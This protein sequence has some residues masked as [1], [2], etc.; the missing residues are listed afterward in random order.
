MP[1]ADQHVMGHP[2]LERAVP[3]GQIWPDPTKTPELHYG[4]GGPTMS[5]I[6]G[7]L[8]ADDLPINP[9][10]ASLPPLIRVPTAGGPLGHWS[11]RVSSTRST[12]FRSNARKATP[13]SR[14]C[15]SS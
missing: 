2:S 9:V 13:C 1:F 3:L 12:P 6:C 4:G 5:M 7:Y 10:L 8:R 15:P 14:A 11:R